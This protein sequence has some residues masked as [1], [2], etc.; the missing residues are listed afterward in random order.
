MGILFHLLISC[1][2][3]SSVSKDIPSFQVILVVLIVDA[4]FIPDS[5]RVRKRTLE[6]GLGTDQQ[7]GE[8]DP[9]SMMGTNIT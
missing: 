2:G 6:R 7:H 1:G 9:P 8:R 4:I 5:M 3:V